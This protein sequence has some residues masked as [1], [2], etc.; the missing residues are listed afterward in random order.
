MGIGVVVGVGVGVKVG[1]EEG[2][3]WGRGV[4]VVWADAGLGFIIIRLE[5]AKITTI[6]SNEKIL[7]VL[8][9]LI[10]L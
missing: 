10:F 7:R 8:P 2:V 3:T 6:R 9:M 5:A 1:F 4:V